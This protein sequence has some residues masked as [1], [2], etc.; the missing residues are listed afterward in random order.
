MNYEAGQKSYKEQRYDE[1]EHLF[2][3]SAQEE[4]TAQGCRVDTL[5]SKYWLARTLYEQEKYAEA[6]QLLRCL[7]PQQEKAFGSNHERTTEDKNLLQ[8]VLHAKAPSASK[9]ALALSDFSRLSD[10]FAQGQE[11]G[12][13]TDSEIQQI[14][15]LLNQFNGQWCTVPRT[16]VILRTIDCLELLDNFIGQ[17]FS[18]Y[19][20][21]TTARRLPSSLNRNKRRQ[22][23]AAQTLVLTKTMS[24]EDENRQH[25]HFRQIES[26]PFKIKGKLGEG[27]FGQVHR[28]RSVNSTAEY[29]LKKLFRTP[30]FSKQESDRFNSIT[31]EI[32]VL[33][34]LRHRHIID[35]VWSYTHPR[36]IGLVISPVADMDL[37]QYLLQA[38]ASKHKELRAHSSAVWRGDWSFFTTNASGTR[39]LN[40]ATSWC[41]AGQSCMP[42]SGLRWTSQTEEAALQS[43]R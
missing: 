10:V 20:V 7:I 21:P 4:E 1:A 26:L 28:V 8:K 27:G 24:L 41:I 23:Q 5:R 39:T 31:T 12:E 43:V 40:P 22:F 34:H 16:Y 33:K 9:N 17:G 35:Y 18:D 29:A 25:G 13:Y 3:K 19:W 42:I 32:K 15:L 11:R 6:E 38:D 14:S 30:T 36:H 37:A 2:R